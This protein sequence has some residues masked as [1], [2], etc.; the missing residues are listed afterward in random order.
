MSCLFL[1]TVLKLV[2]CQYGSVKIGSKMEMQALHLSQ[3]TTFKSI[4]RDNYKKMIL[5]T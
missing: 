4:E 5:P 1:K 2:Y 3:E